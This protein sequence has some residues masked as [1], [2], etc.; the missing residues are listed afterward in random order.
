[1]PE[2]SGGSFHARKAAIIGLGLI[3]GSLALALKARGLA[4][5]VVGVARREETLRE[6][7][8]R[9]VVDQAGRDIAAAIAEA[10][11]VV[12]ATPV[13]TAIAQLAQIAP[14]LAAGCL[15]TD[16]AST[17]AEL[18]AA[19][20]K[21]LPD[22]VHFIGGHPMAGSERSGL[23]A[24]RADLFV[25]ATWV[26]TPAERPDAVAWERAQGLVQ[27]LGAQA[28]VLPAAEHDYLVA[29]ISHL[30]HLLAVALMQFAQDQAGSDP[31]LLSLAAGGFRDATRMAAACPN[32]WQDIYLTN[33]QALLQRLGQLRGELERL[34]LALRSGDGE[35]LHALFRRVQE[36]RHRLWPPPGRGD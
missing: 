5:S 34:E 22:S 20:A 32:M 27:A 35:Q 36:A 23:G 14:G 21:A 8:A 16:V 7:E 13:R 24:A 33:R 4:D 19:A 10:D 18:V 11:L 31:R 9:G 26:L 29:A 1:M 6:A 12:L 17:K 3:G 25:G 28:L 30:P 2:A 15:V